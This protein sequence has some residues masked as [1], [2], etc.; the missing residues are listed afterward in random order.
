LREVFK[1]NKIQIFFDAVGGDQGVKI[2]KILPE[3][4]QLISYGVLSG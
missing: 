4:A 1:A 3:G 2:L